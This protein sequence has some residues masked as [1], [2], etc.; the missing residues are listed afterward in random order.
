MQLN[1]LKVDDVCYNI[2]LQALDL[3]VCM[4]TLLSDCRLTRMNVC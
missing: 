3:L 1:C 4:V 2:L